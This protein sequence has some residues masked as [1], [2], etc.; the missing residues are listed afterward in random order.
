MGVSYQSYQSIN[1]PNDLLGARLTT[2]Y[3]PNKPG[4]HEVLDSGHDTVGG[5]GANYVL[6][7]YSYIQYVKM[8]DLQHQATFAI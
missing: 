1:Q 3:N 5:T 2:S 8:P 4:R 7:M 6:Y